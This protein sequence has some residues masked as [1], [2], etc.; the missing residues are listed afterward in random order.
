MREVSV[1][2]ANNWPGASIGP[3]PGSEADTEPGILARLQSTGLKNSIFF[4]IAVAKAA[5][6]STPRCLTSSS[7]IQAPRRVPEIQVRLPFVA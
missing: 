1:R 7:P 4:V 5:R 2:A 3:V 6:K